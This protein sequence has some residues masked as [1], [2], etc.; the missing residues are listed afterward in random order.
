MKVLKQID[1]AD[2]VGVDR[3]TMSRWLSGKQMPTLINAKRVS[4]KCGVPMEIFVD[5]EIQKFYLGKV[6]L[7]TELLEERMKNAGGGR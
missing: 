4:D 7:K 1:M 6:Y 2:A 5:P 3:G